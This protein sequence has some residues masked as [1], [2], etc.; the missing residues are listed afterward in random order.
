MAN[1]YKARLEAAPPGSFHVLDPEKAKRL[2]AKTLYIPSVQDIRESVEAIPT[3]TTLDTSVI[4]QV[5][6]EREGADMTCP[7][8]THKYLRWLSHDSVLEDTDSFPWWRVLK[9]NRLYAQ[10]PGGTE[11]HARRLGRE[12]VSIGAGIS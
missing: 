7:A 6:A 10:F 11:E 1:P 4:R 2:K 8:A 9:G 5:L 12:G 3:G